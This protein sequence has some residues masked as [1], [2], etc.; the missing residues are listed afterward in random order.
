MDS[1]LWV[2]LLILRKTSLTRFG[3]HN[4]ISYVRNYLYVI[5]L[6]PPKNGTSSGSSPP[7]NRKTPPEPAFQGRFLNSQHSVRLQNN[8]LFLASEATSH[9]WSTP[10]RDTFHVD[11]V[12]TIEHHFGVINLAVTRMFDLANKSIAFCFNF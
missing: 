8:C 12:V 11:L 10:S 5:F 3:Y 7:T 6:L 4:P 2:R 1:V 9:F